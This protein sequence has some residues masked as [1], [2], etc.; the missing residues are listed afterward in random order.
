MLL[1]ISALAGAVI[2]SA[3]P[4]A[5]KCGRSVARLICAMAGVVI[6]LTLGYWLLV[7]RGASL[8][9]FLLLFCLG[10]LITGFL[11]SSVNIPISTALMRV[12][13]R[14]KLSKVD[15]IVSVL[16]QGLTPIAS[17]LAGIVLQCW[18][19]TLLLLICSLGFTAAALFL[20]GSRDAKEI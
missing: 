3:R 15:S 2:L 18:G 8:N 6:A 7:D 14:D 19:S 12:V 11:L 5:E 10:C 13:D 4:Q 20:L 17:V 16:S 9:G 1:G